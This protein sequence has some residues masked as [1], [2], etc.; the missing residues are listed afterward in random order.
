MLE[1]IR[2]KSHQIATAECDRDGEPLTTW[3]KATV[4]INPVHVVTATMRDEREG[5]LCTLILETV[6]GSDHLFAGTDQNLQSFY[7]LVRERYA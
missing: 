3:A 4:Y 1:F 7:E 2:H 5:Q 6:D